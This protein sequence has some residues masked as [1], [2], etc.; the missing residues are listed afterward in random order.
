[1]YTDKI[2]LNDFELLYMAHQKNEMAY[3]ILS[4]KYSALIYRCIYNKVDH[5]QFRFIKE[6]V[7]QEAINTLVHSVDSYRDDCGVLFS[8][9]CMLCINRKLSDIAK[10]MRKGKY[11]SICE[12]SLDAPLDGAA[13]I[14]YGEVVEDTHYEYRPVEYTHF[15]VLKEIMIEAADT[16][17]ETERK[18]FLYNIV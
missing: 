9:F 2:M 3:Q 6:D 18:I 11:L 14:Q 17:D 16:L 13:S 1:M 15:T 4:E 5:K 7:Y 12:C 8:S 10:Q